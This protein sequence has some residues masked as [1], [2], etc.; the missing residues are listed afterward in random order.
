MPEITQ[1]PNCQR[2]LNVPDGQIGSTVRCPACSAEF[3]AEP[4]RA[5]APPP[6]Q[7]E[8][9]PRRPEPRG[10][11]PPRPYDYPPPRPRYDRGYDRP[12]YEGGMPHRGSTVQTL[13]VLCLCFCW[14][15]PVPWIL[16]IIALVMAST[17][18]SQMDTGRMDPA[19]R[20]QTK[21]GQLCAIIGLV[22]S[23]C[24]SFA[25][26]AWY[27]LVVVSAPHYYGGF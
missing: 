10:D 1:C 22:V 11:Y 8:P 9:P 7:P 25:C 3:T 19:G 21:S 15:A 24:L 16:G 26:C 27:W 12:Y 2:K 5:S 17:D 13:G 14:A 4:Y 18:L 6:P 20:S 23:V